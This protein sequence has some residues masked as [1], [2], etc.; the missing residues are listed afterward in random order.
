MARD[1]VRTSLK[2]PM[3]AYLDAMQ[4][5]QEMYLAAIKRAQADL[6]ERIKRATDA[7]AG[8]HETAEA[9]VSLDQPQQHESVQQ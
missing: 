4:R 9:Q 6:V 1:L 3:R 7:V 2:D 5:A 8:D